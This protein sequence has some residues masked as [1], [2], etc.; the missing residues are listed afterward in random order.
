[1]EWLATWRVSPPLFQTLDALGKDEVVR[2]L[3]FAASV[4]EQNT[5]GTQQ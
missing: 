1:M 2:R 5:V 3:N 4:L